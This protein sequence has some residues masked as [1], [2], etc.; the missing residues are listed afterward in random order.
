MFKLEGALGH[1]FSL[2]FLLLL[3]IKSR[4]IIVVDYYFSR[5]FL[6]ILFSCTPL[7]KLKKKNY[8]KSGVKEKDLPKGKMSMNRRIKIN[9]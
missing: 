5:N 6:F 4:Q 2:F 9:K 7:K 1:S 3:L 8:S